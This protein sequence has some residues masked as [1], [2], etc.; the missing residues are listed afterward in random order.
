MCGGG[1]EEYGG[2]GGCGDGLREGSHAFVFMCMLIYCFYVFRCNGWIGE[3]VEEEGRKEKGKNL[4]VHLGVLP[5]NRPV[6]LASFFVNKSD[7]LCIQSSRYLSQSRE[8]LCNL[9]SNQ[10]RS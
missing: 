10:F 9:C 2:Y 4:A 3:C 6:C 8:L 1:P 7:H 5:G